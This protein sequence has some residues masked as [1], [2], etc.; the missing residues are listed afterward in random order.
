MAQ[1]GPLKWH[2][3][4]LNVLPLNFERMK[5]LNL[6]NVTGPNE[7]SS[8]YTNLLVLDLLVTKQEMPDDKEK[9]LWFNELENKVPSLIDYESGGLKKSPVA[10]GHGAFVALLVEL[11]SCELQALAGISSLFGDTYL[12]PG[13]DPVYRI[14]ISCER[15]Q[16]G[17]Y[18]VRAAVDMVQDLVNSKPL[19]ISHHL[20]HIILLEHNQGRLETA[21]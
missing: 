17:M 15:K 20:E 14:V 21:A 8:I 19:D 6:E 5:I 9:S 18:A 1:V 16:T 10:D 13:E 2:G 11:L 7:W 3:S 4:Y 12:V